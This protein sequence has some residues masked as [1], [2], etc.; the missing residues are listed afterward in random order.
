[1]ALSRPVRKGPGLCYSS[2]LTTFSPSSV[3]LVRFSSTASHLS[4]CS[5]LYVIFTNLASAEQN[6]EMNESQW[7]SNT[8]WL[9]M[10]KAVTL[11]D[12][13]K[14]F[15]RLNITAFICWPYQVP[16]LVFGCDW[17]R[18]TALGSC[19]GFRWRGKGKIIKEENGEM[20][21]CSQPNKALLI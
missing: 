20:S 7:N 10:Q 8:F 13:S 18:C 15:C 17:Y 21:L 5:T 4:P 14:E 6:L 2:H 12:G 9:T 1:M 16:V 3:Q 19:I 11:G